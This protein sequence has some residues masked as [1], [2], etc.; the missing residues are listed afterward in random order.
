MNTWMMNPKLRAQVAH[1]MR[2][3]FH[4][5]QREIDQV[6][7]QVPDGTELKQF[8]ETT[9]EDGEDLW[10]RPVVLVES[11]LTDNKFS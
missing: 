11:I 5:S 8:D 3:E 7:K 9:L 2:S 4:W 1:F 10:D 6:L